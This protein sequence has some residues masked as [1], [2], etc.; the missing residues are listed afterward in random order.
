MNRITANYFLSGFLLFNL[1]N[2][3]A[4]TK[5]ADI[6][7]EID[8]LI[9]RMTLEEKIGLVHGNGLFSVAGVERLGI[10]SITMS[11]GPHGVRPE[12]RRDNFGSAN[13]TDDASTYLPVLSAV[14]ATW[15]PQLALQFG[16]V[17]GQES[18]YRG[19]DVILGPGINIIRTP[20]CGRTFE[21]MSE[22]PYLISCLV[23][24]YIKGVQAQDTAAC[25]KHFALNNQE[26]RRNDIDVNLSERALRE[27]YLSGFKAAVQQGGVLAV[28]GSYNKFRGFHCCHNDYLLNQIL[29]KE[30]GF[31][32]AV[33]SDWGGVY[34]TKEAAMNGL[35]IE[36]GTKVSASGKRDDFDNYYMA[37]PLA[38]AIKKGE[39]PQSVLDDK[40]K[41]ILRLMYNINMLGG[42]S[43]QKGSFNTPQH[44]K[45]ALEIAQQAIV[46][47]KND[48]AIL[49]IAG[50][51]NSIAVIGDNAVRKHSYGGGSSEIKAPYEIAPLDGLRKKLNA[52][53]KINFAQG[54]SADVNPPT[55]QLIDEAVA[56]AK[57]SDAAVI[58]CGLNH[59]IEHEGDDRKD[60]KLPYGQ[61][62]LIKAVLAANPKTIV[63]IIA[64]APVEVYNWINDAHAVVYMSYA[65]MES[66]TAMADVL[67]GDVN[68]S[69]KLPVTFPV[70]LQDSPAHALGDY[71]GKDDRENYNEDILVGY[72]YFDTKNIQ[73]QFC[74]GHGLSYTQFRY[75][76]LK[77][78]PDEIKS[79]G[80]ASVS[81]EIENTGSR[82][83]GET[84]QLYIT[85]ADC[86][87]LRPAKELKAFKKVFLKQGE[88]TVVRFDIT[89]SQFL[90]YSEEK[91]QWIA[92]PGKFTVSIG[93]SSRDI[94]L[95][96][97]LKLLD[98]ANWN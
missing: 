13:C 10:P 28:M 20:L 52:R 69:G 31:S 46:L 74:F 85:D 50:D 55:Q 33:I 95:Q 80:K 40:V 9:S 87:V 14:A 42:Q 37:N 66:G 36:M 77:V 17:L 72:R 23:E 82:P 24:Q 21:Y 5:G 44:Q 16:R 59:E 6:E 4:L 70:K 68:P 75:A 30:W 93:S 79:N 41:R 63:A 58:F 71:P 76:N 47:L 35:D 81:L 48:K 62:E 29:K 25:V 15:N 22:D 73:P 97:E 32:G 64:G 43:R 88:K 96:T 84:I 19:K 39:I 56:A 8:N 92:E 60:M 91:K 89:A 54:Y 3:P 61:D 78:E 90:F 57:K 34:N 86:S 83:G 2:C 27:I 12:Q 26:I 67:L 38:N 1:L 94:R 45:T 11:D 18:R 98:Y 53:V 7:K 49:P 51:I 65:G